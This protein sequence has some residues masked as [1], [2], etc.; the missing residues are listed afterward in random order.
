MKDAVKPLLIFSVTVIGIILFSPV[1]RTISSKNTKDL[2]EAYNQDGKAL[3]SV[4]AE[5]YIT[6]HRAQNFV[7]TATKDKPMEI[8]EKYHTYVESVQ[9]HGRVYVFIDVD[10][11][12]DAYFG[13]PEKG[14][15]YY[16]ALTGN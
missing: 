4:I 1:F 12:I 14:M 7:N 2:R 13:S 3:Q 8:P 5:A 11:N 6:T 9:G 15:D 10:G 16:L